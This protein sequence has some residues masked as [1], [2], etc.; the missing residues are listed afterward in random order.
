M[1]PDFEKDNLW[2]FASSIGHV[3]SCQEAAAQQL[4]KVNNAMSVLRCGS[5]RNCSPVDFIV[6][7]HILHRDEN[8]ESY[9]S[10]SW[11]TVD[12]VSALY[13]AKVVSTWTIH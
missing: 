10:L 1:Q 5:D 3:Q 4:A 2:S 9:R 6:A 7:S 8:E 11:I 12:G 13:S